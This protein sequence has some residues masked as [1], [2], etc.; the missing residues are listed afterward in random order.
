M[1]AQ[2]ERCLVFSGL[3]FQQDFLFGGIICPL[4][5]SVDPERSRAIVMATTA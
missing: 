4:I 1:Q 5:F 3:V 2:E